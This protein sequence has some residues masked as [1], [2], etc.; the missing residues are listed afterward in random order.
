M[1]P[2][3][4]GASRR[5]TTPTYQRVADDLELALHAGTAEHADAVV[6]R[7]DIG[8][9]LGALG[10]AKQDISL[11]CFQHG[12][13]AVLGRVHESRYEITLGELVENTNVLAAGPAPQAQ[14]RRVVDI[15]KGE[16]RVELAAGRPRAGGR[17]QRC[18][19]R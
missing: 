4:N 11:Q 10:L 9:W 14:R 8:I 18:K 17:L 13:R 6:V 7:I 12:E 2:S 19:S 16:L 5:T 3:R 1:P 15:A